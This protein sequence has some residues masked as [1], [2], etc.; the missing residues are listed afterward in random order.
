MGLTVEFCE[1]LCRRTLGGLAIEEETQGNV[2][3]R[4]GH[5]ATVLQMTHANPFP[6][7][8]ASESGMGVK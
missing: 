4:F 1:A 7:D 6:L 5:R 3:G 8:T 2:P